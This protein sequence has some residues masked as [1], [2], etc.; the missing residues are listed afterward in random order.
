MIGGI[1]VTHGPMAHPL[2]EAAETI[3]GPVDNIKAISTTQFSLKEI[4][5]EI[6]KIIASEDWNDGIIIMT[7]LRGGSCWNSAALASKNHDRVEVV[8]GV[9]LPMTISFLTK[10]DSLPLPELADTLVRDGIRGI[11]KL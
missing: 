8:S 9:N 11:V 5:S 4:V 10:R 7:S 6:E 3:L 1:I 2:I